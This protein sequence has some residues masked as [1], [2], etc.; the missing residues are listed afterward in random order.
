M[1]IPLQVPAEDLFF[2]AA[3][4]SS[5]QASADKEKWELVFRIRTASQAQARSLFTLFSMARRFVDEGALTGQ[6]NFRQ[7]TLEGYASSFSPQEMAAL[8]FANTPE[9]D[10]NI[11]TLRIGPLDE[12][13]VALLFSMFSLYS[14]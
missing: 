7:N 11:M 12:T 3:G 9:Q 13:G 4:S 1:E 2:G 14:N 8:L 6:H 10:G 5:N